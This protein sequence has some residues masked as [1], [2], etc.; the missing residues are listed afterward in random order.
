MILLDTEAE[1]LGVQG[2]RSKRVEIFLVT[3]RNCSGLSARVFGY[4]IIP[5][6]A[7]RVGNTYHLRR[8]EG[9]SNDTAYRTMG[10]GQDIRATWGYLK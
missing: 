3:V 1:L 9:Y 2:Q 5:P 6:I 8:R 4:K 7:A 10:S